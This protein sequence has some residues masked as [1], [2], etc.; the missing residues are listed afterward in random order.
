[1]P[2]FDFVCEACKS[3]FEELV[4]DGNNP[5][6]PQCGSQNTTRQMSIPSPL[7]TGA[8]P[9]PVK[10]GAVHPLAQKMAMGSAGAN[11]C[12]TCPSGTGGC[13]GASPCGSAE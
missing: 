10:P 8:F 7:K 12:A 13:G 2:M 9:Y 4:R 11:P 6:C 5:T 3:R 1:M